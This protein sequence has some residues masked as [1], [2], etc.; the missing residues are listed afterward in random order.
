MEGSLAAG[1]GYLFGVAAVLVSVL[2]GWVGAMAIRAG[3]HVGGATLLVVALLVVVAGVFALPPSQRMLQTRFDI[4]ISGL[5]TVLVSGG[6]VALA[7][8]IL[9]VALIEW[10]AS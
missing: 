4:E 3:T 10:L 9:F 2:F 6:A 5:R 1:V 7:V 8:A